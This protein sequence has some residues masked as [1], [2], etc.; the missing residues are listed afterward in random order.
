MTTFFENQDRARKNTRNLLL[1]LCTSL[2]LLISGIYLG[3][4][5][6]ILFVSHP[7]GNSFENFQIDSIWH[8]NLLLWISLFLFF[9][10]AIGA[11]Y[12]IFQLREGGAAVARMVGG[13]LVP[14][15]STDLLERKILNVVEEMAIASGIAVPPVYLMKNEHSRLE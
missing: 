1:L 14:P 10:I 5:T 6:V 8:P 13:T 4:A 12:K 3:I 15:N 2:F 9:L 7:T 11:A